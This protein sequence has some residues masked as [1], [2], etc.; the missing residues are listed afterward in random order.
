[1][2]L[3]LV[4]EWTSIY[5]LK[6]DGVQFI[7]VSSNYGTDQL[8]GWWYSIEESDFNGDNRPDYLVGNIGLNTKFKASDDKPFHINTNDFD[9]DN[10]QDIVLSTYYKGDLVPIRGRECSSGEMPFIKEKYPTFEGFANATLEELYTEEKLE[11]SI[12]LEVNTFASIAL[13]SESEGYSVVDLPMN[14]QVSPINR[15]IVEDFDN[16][17]YK[18]IILGGNMFHTEVETPRYDSGVGLMMKVDENGT[19]KPIHPMYSG[20]FLNK[21]VKD[22]TPIKIGDQLSFL[23]SNNNDKIQ[24]FVPNN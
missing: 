13:L 4:G 1:M 10:D 23:V 8:K 16:D 5:M 18:D 24:V 17:G 7:D 2:D 3:I 19:F 21:D 6:N 11:T 14:A 9:D 15:F 22:I 20:I 12:H